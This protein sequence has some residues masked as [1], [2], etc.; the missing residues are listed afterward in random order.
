M[1]DCLII[2]GG[3]VGLSIARELLRRGQQIQVM[4]DA[5]S[6]TV[7]SWAAAGILPPPI[8]RAAHDPLERI[9]ELSHQRFPAWCKQLQGESGLKLDFDRCGG[10]YLARRMGEKISLQVAASQWQ[11][12]GIAAESLTLEAV[13]ERIPGLGELPPE[14]VAYF[15]PD[16]VLVRPPRILKALQ[17]VVSSS[18]SLTHAAL[19]QLSITPA[20]SLANAFDV[21][22]PEGMVTTKNVCLAAGPWT[23]HLLDPLGIRLPMEPRRGQMLLWKLETRPFQAVV[24]EGPR[25]LVARDDGHLLA[26]S[27][28]EDVGFDGSTTTAGLDS[29][30]QFA[31]SLLPCL[32]D[33]EPIKSWAALRPMP[34]DG[35]P[36]LA[37][38]PGFERLFIASGHFRS[39]IHLAPATAELMADLIT[40]MQPAIPIEPFAIQR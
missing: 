29:I 30:R 10:I 14:T 5:K 28:V 23:P 16:E 35:V 40:G 11:A 38:V 25:Y 9:R 2:G 22:T 24:N 3:I 27:T 32:A 33:L 18:G 31:V 37:P 20:A 12:D 1:L 8:A 26:G 7:A 19:D 34:M 4:D 17:K 39:G 21:A 13:R 36:Y 6:P 15:L